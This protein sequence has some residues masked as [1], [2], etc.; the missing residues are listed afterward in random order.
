MR[1]P[2]RAENGPEEGPSVSQHTIQKRR[3][4]TSKVCVYYLDDLAINCEHPCCILVQAAGR[5]NKTLVARARGLR[6]ERI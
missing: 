5:H 1:K 6:S 2:E 3:I 4:V